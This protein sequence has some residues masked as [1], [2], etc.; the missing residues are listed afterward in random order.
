MLEGKKVNL[1]LFREDD[2]EEYYRLYSRVTER[3]EYFPLTIQ[4]LPVMRKQFAE[5]GW[6]AENE[7]RMLI[8]DK[9]GKLVGGI[10]YFRGGT[11]HVPF[12]IGYIVFRPDDRNRGYM[13]EALR[14]FSAH[15]FESKPIER[16]ELCMFTGNAA[17]R[18]V[19]ERC[20]Y[21]YEG[22]MRRAGLL[23]GEWRDVE[24]F[25]LL[26]EECPA[27]ADALRG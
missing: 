10:A 9:G 22:T 17:S 3:G 15:M 8:T 25:S 14:I 26:R 6:W 13:R 4:S 16:L 24:M 5:T 11:H 20:G 7:G 21:R 19:A 23:R 2:L 12:E 27:L 18:R 1:R